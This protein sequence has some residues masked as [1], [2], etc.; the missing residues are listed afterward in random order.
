MLDGV[1]TP[2][3]RSCRK[4]ENHVLL[5]IG[6]IFLRLAIT[7]TTIALLTKYQESYDIKHSIYP[8]S[9]LI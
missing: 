2:Q 6:N 9:M 4:L 8:E 3:I 5:R 7:K 1:D